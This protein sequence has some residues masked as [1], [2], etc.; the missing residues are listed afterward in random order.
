VP[1]YWDEVR[2]I[3]QAQWLAEHDVVQAVPGLRPADAFFGHPPGLHVT[4]AV[5]WKLLG[6]SVP[7][8]HGLMAI[9][10]AVGVGA[11]F[12]LGRHLHDTWTGL[13]AALLLLA[14]P[15][16]LAQAGMY[17]A[18]LPVTA[19]GVLSAWFVMRDRFAAWTL[20]ATY[21]VLVKETAI[22]I[23]VAILL[24]RFLTMGAPVR[25]RVLDALKHGVPLYVISAFFVLQ[26]ATTGHFFFIYATDITLVSPGLGAGV[27]QAVRIARWLFVEQA[28]G[29]LVL[30]V[31][32]A[33]IVRPT[34][35][36]ARTLG[37][38]ALVVLLSGFSFAVLFYLPRYVLPVVPFLCIAGAAAIGNMFPRPPL[39]LG[40]AAVLL[41]A[42]VM[43]V[44]R[45]P[46]SGNGEVNMN[47]LRVVALQTSAVRTLAA[48]TPV[49]RVLTTGRLRSQ[50]N[51]PLLG[52]VSSPMGARAFRTDAD[53]SGIDV[54]MVT[55]PSTD[56]SVVLRDLAR[57]AG[58]RLVERTEDGPYFVEI[59]EGPGPA[60][61]TPTVRPASR[62]RQ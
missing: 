30:A 49:P 24:Y 50:L 34:R 48:R 4:L 8:A 19:L 14:T 1:P 52:H 37:L 35:A 53:T 59:Y 13:L 26:W 15:V 2:Y 39:R 21:M 11:T 60:L 28:R 7:L 25:V 57:R 42:T 31:L 29:V 43:S 6:T 61:D 10:A 12:L 47:Y 22:A 51:E 41:G 9:F 16:Y 5:L 38:T 58:W 20:I 18:D 17:L 46:A 3:Q 56:G 40:A 36:L 62:A 33:A 32:L 45:A 23:V 55:A 44:F 27:R 54:I